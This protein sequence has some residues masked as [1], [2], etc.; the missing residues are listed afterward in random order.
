M[1]QLPIWEGCS[2]PVRPQFRHWSALQDPPRGGLEPHYAAGR[3]LDLTLREGVISP[4]PTPT[5]SGLGMCAVPRGRSVPAVMR[6][7]LPHCHCVHPGRGSRSLPAA[8]ACLLAVPPSDRLPER[9]GFIPGAILPAGMVAG[10]RPER[11]LFPQCE[12]VLGFTRTCQ[13]RSVPMS[14]RD[15]GHAQLHPLVAGFRPPRPRLSGVPVWGERR[16]SGR[17]ESNRPSVEK[18]PTQRARGRSS[19]RIQAPV[20][21]R[22]IRHTAQGRF[23]VRFLYAR[24]AA[25]FS[26][27]CFRASAWRFAR[28][29]RIA[30]NSMAFIRLARSSSVMSG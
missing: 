8:R 15:R 19:D 13:K 9:T 27:S 18:G 11:H 14:F 24:V 28:T 25:T 3:V 2:S 6:S 22:V 7:C 30:A 16:V 20:G 4:S 23:Y 21:C 17:P 1:R 26:S 29:R 12:A 10:F 5:P